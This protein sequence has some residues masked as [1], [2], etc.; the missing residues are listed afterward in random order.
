MIET[1]GLAVATFF[2]T[3]GPIDIAAVIMV[4]FEL[5]GEVLLAGLGISLFALRTADGILLLLIGIDK[6]FA[7]SS[8]GTV[9]DRRGRA[10]GDLETGYFNISDSYAPCRGAWCYG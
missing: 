8:G 3:I 5:I 7:R 6:V 4:T 2:A 9:H 10:R 1:A